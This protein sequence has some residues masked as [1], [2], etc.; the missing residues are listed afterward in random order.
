MTTTLTDS[1]NEDIQKNMDSIQQKLF[2]SNLRFKETS[3]LLPAIICECDTNMRFLYT[4]RL[5]LEMFGYS[6]EDLEKGIYMTDLVNAQDLKIIEENINRVL[7]GLKHTPQVYRLKHK[8]GC[9]R[10]YYIH[11]SPI[12]RNNITVGLR[13]CLTD[14]TPIK[15]AEKKHLESEE[16]FRI[17][18]KGSPI[19]IA[20]CNSDLIINEI[21]DSF[22]KMFY[23]TD[24]STIT[25]IPFSLLEHIPFLKT[26]R[27]AIFA[28]S[29]FNYESDWDFVFVNIDNRWEIVPTG[30]RYLYWQITPLMCTKQG[31]IFLIQV[32][33]ITE[34]KRKE[35]NRIALERSATVKA[36]QVAQ[37]LRK[38]LS[39]RSTITKMNSRSATMQK[40]L[41]ILPEISE[42]S[43]TILVCGESGTGKEMVAKTVHELSL[44]NNQPFI[45]INCGA[46]PDALLE[47]ELFGYKA[48]AFTDAKNDKIGKFQ[49][50]EGGT[51]FLDEI[52]EMTPA[53]QV[54]LLRVIQERTFEPLG[55]VKSIKL[56]VRLIVATNRNLKEMVKTGT[57]REDLYYRIKVVTIELPPLRERRCD[58]PLLINHFILKFNN[59][60]KKN[61]KEVSKSALAILLAHDYTGNIR[62]LEHILEHAFVFCKDS[63]I[64]KEHLPRDLV[65]TG[66]V[67]QSY[68][69]P[70]DKATSFE[71]LEKMYL[72]H[73]FG[74]YKGNKTS[75][76]KHLGVH[77]STLFRRCKALKLDAFLMEI[78]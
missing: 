46:L 49:L 51:L 11:S 65:S 72:F 22:R 35:D 41:S 30:N 33:D 63:L 74:K 2:E 15:E 19:G 76:V 5:G 29:V 61:I 8:D 6:S 47:S 1:S 42:S 70:F 28:G 34:R 57:F 12:I 71:E 75:V 48:G 54:K 32:Q 4:N 9:F 44:R 40:I 23:L 69:N 73:L 26:N 21:N 45:A 64:E 58:I 50:A 14:I 20:I 56:N 62:E 18:Y 52:G 66:F 78:N 38:E 36:V 13:S 67:S 17:I 53:M 39:L 77:R 68:E 24:E 43:A 31:Q 7:S 59:L 16:R 27:D 10:D 55:G 60:Y 37:E 25:H 3:E